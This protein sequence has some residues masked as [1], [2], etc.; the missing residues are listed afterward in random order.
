MIKIKSLKQILSTPPTPDN[1]AIKIINKSEISYLHFANVF[2][3]AL[4]IK[5]FLN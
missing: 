3:I 1:Y 4:E 2:L 5:T